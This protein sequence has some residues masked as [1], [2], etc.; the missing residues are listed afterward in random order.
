LGYKPYEVVIFSGIGCSSNFPHF[1]SAYG[2][3]AVH[4]RALPAATGAHL[5]NPDLKIVVV[6]GDGDGYA[7]GMGHFIHACRRNL[8]LTYM[9]MNNQIYGLTLGQY[10]PSSQKGHVTKISPEGVDENPV[11]PINLALA[12]GAT[13]V[14]RGFSGEIKHLEQTVMRALQ[15]EGFGFIDVLSPCVTFNRLNTYEWFKER[16]Y[17]LQEESHDSNNLAMALA[18]GLEW[19]DRIPI[20][21]FYENKDQQPL[22]KVIPGMRFGTPVKAPLGFKAMGINS[23]QVFQEFR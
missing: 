20:G 11:N 9:V 2:F 21:V 23:N 18:K 22:H 17:D 5:S 12:A 3:H 19:G 1:T 14:A 10:S 16:T 13:F 4:G 7:I 15:H 6:G 8:N